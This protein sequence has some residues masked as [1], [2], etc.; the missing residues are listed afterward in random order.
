MSTQQVYRKLFTDTAV[1]GLGSIVPRVFNF[2]LVPLHT[3]AFG[4]EAYGRIT[5]T[6]GWIA[7][8]NVIFL[9]GM[10]TAYLRFS[11]KN[12]GDEQKTFQTA[13]TVIFLIS[14]LM[15]VLMYSAFNLD[16]LLIQGENQ[17]MLM[18]AS[19]TLLIDSWCAIPFVR[20]RLKNETKKFAL[21]KISNVAL[22]VILNIWFLRT[23]TAG[24]DMVFLAN[25]LANLGFLIYFLPVL[26]SWRPQWNNQLA[27]SMLTYSFPVMLT[28]LAGMTNEMFSR[29]SIDNW[30]PAN[31]YPGQSPAYVQGIF[32]ACYKF[33]ILMTLVVQA[34]RMAAEPFFFSRSEQKD[35]PQVFAKVNH[36]F[37]VACTFFLMAICFNLNW[38]KFLVDEQYWTG[39]GIVPWLLLG[40]L[41]L[42][43]Y[44]NLTVWFKVTDKT[45]YGTLFATAGA[46]ITVFMNYMLIPVYG[47]MGSA[48]V[49][50]LSYF[51]MTVMCYVFGQKYYPIPYMIG[52]DLLT[53]FCGFGVVLLFN[54]VHSDSGVLDLIHGIIATLISALV[55]W[56]MEKDSFKAGISA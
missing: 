55:F 3:R 8:L 51:L 26:V 34:F 41:F 43:V 35:S 27:G 46:L 50:F 7:I 29:I 6:Y 54:L 9:F 22:L 48:A 33:A 5:D 21:L 17:S 53:I 13:Q 11:T 38:L 45:F 1:Y 36:Y 44:Y 47:I 24:P 4:P 16:L 56:L 31:F 42:G 37:I 2:F 10:E 19:V 28:G 18:Y 15:T 49:T 14:I 52:R 30:L 20:L 25:M 40:Y 12:G 23:G 39:L 32:G